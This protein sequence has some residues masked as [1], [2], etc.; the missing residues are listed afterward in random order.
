MGL[1]QRVN[2]PAHIKGNMLDLIFTDNGDARVSVLKKTD[3]A[4]HLPVSIKIP[5]DI[6]IHEGPKRRLWMYHRADWK[7]LSKY[8]RKRTSSQKLKR[9]SSEGAVNYLDK[10]IKKGMTIYIPTIVRKIRSSSVPWFDDDCYTA[11]RESQEGR[12][13]KESYRQLLQ[14]KQRQHKHKVRNC[15]CR[16]HM[17]ERQF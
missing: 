14:G 17:S 12:R 3:I 8:I 6:T 13:S 9:L 7:G 11:M 2:E 10:T 4:D 1:R 15:I 5:D 16:T